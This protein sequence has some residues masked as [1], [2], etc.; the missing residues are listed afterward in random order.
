MK[1]N[2]AWLT[3][4]AAAV[5][6]GSLAMAGCASNDGGDDAAEQASVAGDQTD[7]TADTTS[8]DLGVANYAA[9]GGGA[10]GGGAHGG[11]GHAGHGRGGFGHAGHGRGGFGHAGWGR[12]YGHGR[13]WGW[14]WGGWRRDHRWWW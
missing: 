11:R 9:H 14:G 1:L 6:T 8:D 7:K 12:G 2:R 13:G 10:H 4:A 5:L 3:A